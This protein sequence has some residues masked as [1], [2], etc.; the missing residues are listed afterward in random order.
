MYIASWV[1]MLTLLQTTAMVSPAA[2]T[3]SR[4][5]SWNSPVTAKFITTSGVRLGSLS[6]DDGGDLY[7][8]EGRPQEKGRQV[9]VRFSPGDSSANERGAVDVSPGDVNVRTRVHEYGGGAYVQAP[10]G[11]IVYSDFVSQRL[12]WRK[13][14]DDSLLCLTPESDTAPNGQYRFADAC[15]H[16]SGTSIVC[17]REDH[18]KTGDAKPSEVINEVVTVALDGSGA[19]TVLASGKDFYA[20]PRVSPDGASVAYVC[21]DH[22]SMPWDATELRLV[23]FTSGGSASPATSEHILVAGK[24]GDTSVLQPAWHPS[25]SALYFISD[26]SG[27]WNIYRAPCTAEHITL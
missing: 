6:L 18:S 13:P 21:W 12:F 2:K 4:Y 15:V 19:M 7:W 26:E 23:P 25:G 14:G 20:H 9:V 11:G 8:L 27:Y 1:L 17:V 22:P 5:G 24:D 3:N 16:P 10:G